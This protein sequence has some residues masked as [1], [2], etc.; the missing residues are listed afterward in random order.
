MRQF[1]SAFLVAF[2]L[3]SVM[4]PSMASAQVVGVPTGSGSEEVSV[5]ELP[6][7]LSP[8]AIRELVSRLSDD[9]V[10]MLLLDQLDAVAEAQAETAGQRTS[11]ADSISEIGTAFYTPIVTAVQRLPLLFSRQAEALSNF[12]ATF[13]ADGLLILAALLVGV[14][15]VGYAAELLVTR[16]ILRARPADIEP[17]AD[18]LRG[19]LGF[20]GRRLARELLG[21]VVFYVVIRTIGASLLTAEQAMVLAPAVRLLILV[22]RLISALSRFALAP[23]QPN[24]RLLNVND[25][26][27]KYLH[28]NLIGLALLGG[29]T[30]FIV[31]FNAQFGVPVGEAR[32]GFWLNLALHIYIVVITW[33]AREGLVEMM[34]G[35]DPDR[36]R[37]D[38]QTA[39][40][41][42]YFAMAVSVFTWA[43]AVI[44]AGFGNF[45]LL[46]TAPHYTTMFWLLMAPLIDAAIRG[47]VRH[48]QPPMIGDGPIAEQAYKA[49]KRSL[50][51]IGRV[52]A[53]GLI[54]LII[55][56]AWN[57]NLA[58]V[59]SGGA[60]FAGNLIQF[61]VISAIGYIL[62]E[63]V[64]LWINRRLTR[65]NTTA[66]TSDQ[67]AGEG[68]GAGG[69]RLATVLPL[70]LIASQIAIGTI[71]A[72][73]AIG[74]LGI[75]I[76]PLLAGAGILGL[77]I[78]FGAQKLVTD[79]VSG[80]FFLVDD[81]F[82]VGEYVDVGGTMGSVE[83]I[84]IRSMQLRHH[85]GN[86]HTIP[87]GGIE[88]VTNFSRDW[89]IMKLMFTVP[90]DT[91]PNKVKKIF[92]KIG[93]EMMEDPLF[94]DDFLEPFK[95]QGVFQ[96]DDVGIVMRGKFMAK[97][98]TQFTIRKEIYNRVRAAF[99]ANGIEFARREVR[100][101][102]PGME[103][104]DDLNVE[105]QAAVQAGATAAV[106]THIEE[107]AAEAEKK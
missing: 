24:M 48:L 39:R 101:A 52:L 89:V 9:Q 93:A 44:V 42:P 90:F 31:G 72:L 28:R 18:T 105:Q 82:R 40:A 27:A 75:D 23:H 62:Y 60:Q 3:L 16:V 2:V 56:G 43:L 74:S 26:W 102:I 64:S 5:P 17:S 91:D 73:L 51:R 95:S 94:K 36:T 88:K 99:D 30:M 84:S 15:A 34:R 49:N 83:K 71:F 29:F 59:G 97:P 76:T 85:R 81:A 21:L 41:Y 50:I 20:L 65:E 32:I 13:G 53:F 104:H 92:K 37:Y 61:M 86:V 6:E 106:Q 100:V 35:T 54:L 67:E 79:I 38:E 22:P 98:G 57:I 12:A 63:L 55:A 11:L 4:A 96:F 8:E 107:Q 47:L 33:K 78:G 103:D 1:I 87:Y 19:T 58:D 80:I 14:L 68:G 66:Q 69:S 77:A 25:H 70:V 10:R 7:P 45:E 46:M